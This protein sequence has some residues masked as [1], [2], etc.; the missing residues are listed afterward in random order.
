[1]AANQSTEDAGLSF[2]HPRHAAFQTLVHRSGVEMD[3]PSV[4]GQHPFE[5][6]VEQA[7]HRADL[8]LPRIPA[9]AAK[10]V[11]M[12]ALLAPGE[13]IAGK[14]VRV[15]VEENGVAFRVAGRRNHQHSAAEVDRIASRGLQLDR[16]RLRMDIIAMQ[17]AL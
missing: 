1:M 12:S 14:K 2:F 15:V 3:R 13:R 10:R 16:R 8:L 5:A 17:Y 9:G 11:K 4:A 6:I 7:F